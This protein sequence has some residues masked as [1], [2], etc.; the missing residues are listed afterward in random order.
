MEI[1][2]IDGVK[3]R[4]DTRPGAERSVSKKNDFIL[5]KNQR[6]LDF[7][8]NWKVKKPK[9]IME[10]GMFE[11]GS[12]VLMDKLFKPK[13]IVGLD[14]RRQPI[15]PLED[16]VSKNPQMK[17]YYGRSQDKVGTLMA[18]RE[19][20]PKGIDFVVDDASHLYDQTRATFEMLFPM[21]TQG[22]KYVIEDW[23]WAHSPNHQKKGST[24]HDRTAMSNLI[25]Q[26]TVLAA[27]YGVIEKVEVYREFVCVTK[28]KGVLPKNALDL[29]GLL[30]GREM[31]LL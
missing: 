22:G 28:G 27:R 21:V 10:I 2:K 3:F 15:E 23:S 5:V 12:L 16:Y 26:L 17:T 13:K 4:L 11:G 30:R 9:T 20:F 7:Y 8:K 14:L 29:D 18:A 6:C 19:N 31:P 1:M 25:V 24:W